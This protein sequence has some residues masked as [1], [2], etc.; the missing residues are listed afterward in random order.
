MLLTALH[1]RSSR[2]PPVESAVCRLLYV[3]SAA[4]VKQNFSL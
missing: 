3:P 2:S 4:L 1:F